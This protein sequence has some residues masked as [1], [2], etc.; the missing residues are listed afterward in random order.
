MLNDFNNPLDFQQPQSLI[1]CTEETPYPRE[2]LPPAIKDAV[3]EA[4]QYIKA[5]YPMLATAAL[6][7]ISTAIQMHY[8]MRG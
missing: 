3:D 8:L 2:S 1:S 6:S 4:H 5:P 7:A